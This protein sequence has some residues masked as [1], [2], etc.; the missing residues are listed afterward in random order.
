MSYYINDEEIFTEIN[1]CPF[2]RMEIETTEELASFQDHNCH[3]R[4]LPEAKSIKPLDR[5]MSS[6][7]FYLTILGVS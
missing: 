4:Q 7:E 5:A 2:C 6:R 1:R 3:F